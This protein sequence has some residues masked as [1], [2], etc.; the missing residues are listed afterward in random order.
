MLKG[1]CCDLAVMCGFW[2][3]FFFSSVA[4]KEYF[5]LTTGLSFCRSVILPECWWSTGG[6]KWIKRKSFHA[7]L[8]QQIWIAPVS[9][10]S[11]SSEV[12]DWLNWSC[13]S[14]YRSCSGWDLCRACRESVLHRIP[15]NYLSIPNQHIGKWTLQFGYDISGT[16]GVFRLSCQVKRS[17]T[18][19]VEHLKAGFSLVCS[20]KLK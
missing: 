20:Y 18:G 8:S 15:V 10:A 12:M 4:K 9:K 1:L 11:P 5:Y 13:C 3:L 17:R 14:K 7:T 2:N 6:W 19:S 16:N